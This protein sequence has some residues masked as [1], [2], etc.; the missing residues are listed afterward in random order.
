[1]SVFPF[2][3]LSLCSSGRPPCIS[4][5]LSF[6]QPCSS[7]LHLLLQPLCLFMLVSLLCS[8]CLHSSPFLP[9]PL[10]PPL[11]LFCVQRRARR[12]VGT[13]LPATATQSAC[14]TSLVGKR[15][16]SSLP[17]C[18]CAPRMFSFWTSRPTTSTLSP[19]ML[20][21]APLTTFRAVCIDYVSVRLIRSRDTVPRA[22]CICSGR[23]M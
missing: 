22:L 3:S 17:S 7:T 16:V 1:M 19:L 13:V 9:H 8:I 10:F 21:S 5:K 6:P 11:H 12:W 15:H 20:S 23:K 14:A 2:P 18:Q 4:H